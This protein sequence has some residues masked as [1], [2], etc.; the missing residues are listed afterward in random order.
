MTEFDVAHVHNRVLNIKKHPLYKY[1]KPHPFVK[2]RETAYLSQ[3][4]DSL[5][6]RANLNMRT[7]ERTKGSSNPCT[8]LALMT[9]ERTTR[10]IFGS[11]S[12]S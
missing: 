11:I 9:D 4:D 6:Q 12:Y 7:K 3:T 8:K 2:D 1:I 5:E 10:R